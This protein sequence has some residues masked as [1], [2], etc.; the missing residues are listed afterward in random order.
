[1]HACAFTVEVIPRAEVG[2]VAVV[3]E[4]RCGPTSAIDEHVERLTV[5][6]GGSAK[7]MMRWLPD[8]PPGYEL[9]TAA[10]HW[11]E[12]QMIGA[13][14]SRSHCLALALIT[15]ELVTNAV[16][17][18][19]GPIFVGVDASEEQTRVEVWDATPQIDSTPRH[20][21]A[22]DGEVGGWGLALVSRLSDRWGTSRNET[23][24]CVWSEVVTE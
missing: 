12:D 15:S 10:R 23:G 16:M 1:L 3:P 22:S 4:R 6:H 18:A 9:V 24:K 14:R 8:A 13:G 17:H 2:G 5:S 19:T 7:A 21:G 11:I 20:R